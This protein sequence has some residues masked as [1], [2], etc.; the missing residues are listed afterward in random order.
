VVNGGISLRTPA[1]LGNFC[2][3]IGGFYIL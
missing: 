3:L 1:M 2:A